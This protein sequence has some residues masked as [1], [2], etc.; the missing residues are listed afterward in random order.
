MPMSSPLTNAGGTITINLASPAQAECYNCAPYR[1]FTA[2]SL[3]GTAA[4]A[5][6]SAASAVFTVGSAGT[7]TVASTGAPVAALSETG[8]L[9]S[10]V[11]FVDNTDGT[12]TL[13]GT[14]GVGTS[15]TYA[16]TITAS[17]SVAPDATQ[18]FTLTVNE[19]PTITSANSATFQNGVASSFTVT[20]TGVPAPA[21][22]VSGSLPS[23]VT[24]TDNG[25][26][27]AS[28]S[29]TSTASGTYNLTIIA[30]NGAAPDA[31]Q[32]FT[33][34]VRAPAVVLSPTPGLTMTGML[35]LGLM[36]MLVVFVTGRKTRH[37][38]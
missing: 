13:A 32:A 8:T 12:A 15:G 7:F 38:Q 1:Q 3:V 26:G 19:S 30:S 22:S 31:T 21:L 34:V 17:N 14:P 20:T 27:T 16:L 25:N 11:T 10:G 9:P 24:F 2:G 4:P 29:G 18:N 23:G 33:L 35:V 36:L 28:L 5:I 37:Q 6:T